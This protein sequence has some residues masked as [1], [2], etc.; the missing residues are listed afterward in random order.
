MIARQMFQK[1][2]SDLTSDDKAAFDETQNRRKLLVAQLAQK[3][4]PT[5]KALQA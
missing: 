5:V 2:M 4:L 1:S 3:L